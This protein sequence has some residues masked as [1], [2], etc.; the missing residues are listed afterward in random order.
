MKYFQRKNGNMQGYRQYV[1]IYTILIIINYFLELKSF[2]LWPQVVYLKDYT[3][4][5][6]DFFTEAHYIRYMVVYPIFFLSDA[7]KIDYNIIFTPIVL[8]LMMFTNIYLDKCL[9]ILTLNKKV[10][11]LK[12]QS[13]NLILLIS[14][15]LLMN[16]RLIFS[17]LGSIITF[18]QLLLQEKR[19][20]SIN[21]FLIILSFCLVNV[22]SGTFTVLIASYIIFVLRNIKTISLKINILNALILSVFI[23]A[24]FININKTLNFHGNFYSLLTHGFGNYFYADSINVFFILIIAILMSLIYLVISRRKVGV[25]DIF[26]GVGI[27]GL[28]IGYSSFVFLMPVFLLLIDKVIID[29]ENNINKQRH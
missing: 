12:L 4:S 7:T 15:L 29:Y 23:P 19:L 2:K 21:P 6:L 16:G 8:L 26:I 17:M 9:P 22:S 3:P 27:A 24:W 18:Y 10:S 11:I 13:I 25:F 28:Q 5:Q 20:K 14:V 1:L